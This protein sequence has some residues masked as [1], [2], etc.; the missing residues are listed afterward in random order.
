M[1]AL[2]VH[3]VAWESM[4]NLKSASRV[5][6]A[7]AAS[8]P[9]GLL[10]V[11][12]M[13][14][15]T[16][17]LRLVDLNVRP[18]SAAEVEWADLVLVSAMVCHRASAHDVLARCRQARKRVVAGGPLFTSHPDDYA[19]VDHLVLDEAELT[20]PAFLTDLDAGRARHLYRSPAK[21]DL[22]LTPVPR[23]DLLAVRDYLWM[24]VQFSRG[25]PFGCEFC[26]VIRL[27]GREWRTKTVDQVTAELDALYATGWRGY[28]FVAD[29]NFAAVPARTSAFVGALAEWQRDH[30]HPFVLAT[31]LSVQAAADRGLIRRM[32]DA[33]FQYAAVGIESPIDASLAEVGKVQNRAVGLLEAV[34]AIQDSGIIVIGDFMVGFDHDPP[35]VCDRHMAFIGEAPVVMV[36]PAVL[37]AYHGTPLYERLLAEGR[38]TGKASGDPNLGETNVITKIDANELQARYWRMLLELYSADA[39]YRRVRDLLRTWRPGRRMPLNRQ[40][41]SRVIVSALR[42]G[43]LDEPRAVVRFWLT[44]AQ[45]IRVNHRAWPKVFALAVFGY[46]IRRWVRQR[47]PARDATGAA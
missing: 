13:L 45:V 8:P 4:W 31:H 16:W 3:P 30:G 15:S 19:E 11:A 35:D 25:C 21:P 18:L 27:Y 34:R 32:A 38:I 37:Q 10:T 6:G 7:R 23:W 17:V 26:D 22:A 44:L 28:V 42:V 2:L 24:T 14:P 9:L 20:L 12:A 5:V 1:N 29:D 33:G 47:A 39:F 43:V 46:Q 40:W 36:N 41:L